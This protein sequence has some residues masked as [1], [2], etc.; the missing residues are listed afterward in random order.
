MTNSATHPPGLPL[1]DNHLDIIGKARSGWGLGDLETAAR[2]DITLSELARIQ[3][4]EILPEALRKLAPALHL[5][6]EALLAIAQKTWH[7]DPVAVPGLEIF[8]TPF[9]DITVN[10]YLIRDSA[11]NEAVVF[12]SGADATDMLAFAS[13]KGLNIRLILITHTHGD[14]IFDLD[15]LMEKTGAPAFVGDREPALDGVG[16]FP[17]GRVFQ[18]GKLFIGTRLTWGH[19][20]GGITY[21]VSGLP[22]AVAVVGDALFAGST[23]GGKVSWPDA[24]RTTREEILSL[25]DE[26]VLACGHGPLT[27]VREEKIHNPF[28]AVPAQKNTL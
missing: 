3:N 13:S 20:E 10:S 15:R 2:A 23:G 27:T 19:A 6:P 26:T 7:P 8:T 4:G 9:G 14:H 28:F 18:V 24:L 25:S 16:T 11:S 5:E 21:V 17:A 12:D 1:E 22:R